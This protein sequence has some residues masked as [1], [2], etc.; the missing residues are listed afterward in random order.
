MNYMKLQARRHGMKLTEYGL[1]TRSADG[2]LSFPLKLNS[3][4]EIFDYFDM[5]YIPPENRNW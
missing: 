3:E 5:D 4:R 1:Q 2:S